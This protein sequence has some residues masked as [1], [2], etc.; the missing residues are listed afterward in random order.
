MGI[1][2][3]QML[4]SL[5]AFVASS[6]VI[7]FIYLGARHY[8]GHSGASSHGA[9]DEHAAKEEHGGHDE[10]VAKDAHSEHG[11]HAAQ[12][13]HDSGH[14]E[15]VAKD[16]HS[17]HSAVAE[18]AE[19]DEH[20]EKDGHGVTLAA[21]SHVSDVAKTA[22]DQHAA[23]WTYEGSTGPEHWASIAN[24]NQT[25]ES[26]K[27][28]SPVDIRKPESAE[29]P[30]P[31]K[32]NYGKVAGGFINNGHTLQV[33]FPKGNFA[34][35]AGHRYELAQMH[36]HAPSEHTID[37]KH[38]DMEAHFVHKDEK[39]NLAVIGVLIEKAHTDHPALAKIWNELPH[40]VNATPIETESINP[41]ELMPKDFAYYH[42]QGS[43]TTPPCSEGVEWYV[44]SSPVQLSEH[45][46]EAFTK[47]V[48][49]NSRPVQPLHAR[50]VEKA[51]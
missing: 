33:N 16:D 50:L 39:G 6:A 10:H 9:H 12:E 1:R 30:D 7:A 4:A 19:H 42:Y 2:N 46:V 37:G 27:R 48:S 25:C 49:H 18:N 41:K 15:H 31:I 21:K 35:L 8:A 23:H 14:D 13:E 47:I 28:Q 24:E 32:L 40:E 38:F 20:A 3:S 22:A 26:G 17:E 51:E 5:F 45:Q 43:L 36:F 34:N 29:D 11:D 44:L